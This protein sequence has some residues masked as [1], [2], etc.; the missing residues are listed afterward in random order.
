MS[1]SFIGSTL[2]IVAGTPATEDQAGYEALSYTEVGKIVSIGEL[3]DTSEDISFDLLKPGRKTHVNGVKDIG[4]VPIVLE[5]DTAD[6]GQVILEAANNGNVTH[7]FRVTD[8]D[9][10]DVYFQGLVANMRDNERTA[11]N[12]K[13]KSGVLRGQSGITRV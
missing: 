6:A 8:S 13:G 7:S 9:G 2:S 11:S 1:I 3:G 12:Y 10:E 4:E 5:T